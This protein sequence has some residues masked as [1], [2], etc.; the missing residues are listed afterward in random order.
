MLHLKGGAMLSLL[1]NGGIS[2]AGWFIWNGGAN[3]WFAVFFLILAGFSLLI[4]ISGIIRYAF[5]LKTNAPESSSEEELK[6]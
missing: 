2:L 4:L 1:V 5:N 6:H 3:F